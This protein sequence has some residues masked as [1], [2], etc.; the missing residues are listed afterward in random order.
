MSKTYRLEDV[1][2]DGFVTG[3]Q[4][5]AWLGQ[6]P[7]AAE[8]ERMFLLAADPANGTADEIEARVMA[9]RARG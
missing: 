2:V 4:F 6:Y 1:A 5:D 8:A 9:E 3:E 7:T